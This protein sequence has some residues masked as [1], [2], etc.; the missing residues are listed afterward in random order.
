MYSSCSGTADPNWGSSEASDNFS[1]SE[2]DAGGVL[3]ANSV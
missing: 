1:V 3:G 2:E